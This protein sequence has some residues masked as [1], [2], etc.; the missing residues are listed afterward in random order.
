MAELLFNRVFR[1]YGIPEDIV[2]DRGP[3][4]ISR[5]WKA[6]FS[7][8]GV[9]VRLTSG[10]H[11]QSNGQTERKI[12]E[13]GRFLRTF[14]HGHQN[15][16]NQ[17][18]G[19]AGFQPPLFPWSG[20]PSDMPA[21]DYWFQERESGT[22][23][24]ISCSRQCAGKESRPTPVDQPHPY[25][26]WGKRCGYLLGTSDCAC[27]AG[28]SVPDLLA[29]SPSWNKS[30]QSPTDSNC[31]LSTRFTPHSMCHYLNPS[32]L[33]FSLEPGRP[34]EPPPPS[35][36]RR[37]INYRVKEILESRRLGGRSEYLSTGRV[38]AL[39]NAHGFPER[40]S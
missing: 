40:T 34:E 29:P 12:Q 6:F 4:F 30:I 38:M 22:Q 3:Q 25:T 36:R 21:V 18:L 33:L 19:W 2:S 7:L 28:N 27:L 31:L 13:V 9:T 20:E 5:V 10:Y 23:P 39:K 14:C 35:N 26:S 16:W 32:L 11:P 17:F 1:Y 37:R 24:T 8:L 15:S